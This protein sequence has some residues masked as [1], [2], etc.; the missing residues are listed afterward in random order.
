MFIIVTIVTIIM[1]INII[2]IR[3]RQ[4]KIGWIGGGVDLKRVQEGR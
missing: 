1:I 4:D 3:E 2:I